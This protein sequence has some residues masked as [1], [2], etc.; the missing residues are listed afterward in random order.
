MIVCRKGRNKKRQSWRAGR[1][2]KEW[3]E[4]RPSLRVL[5]T[6]LLNFHLSIRELGNSSRGL[7]RGAESN[8]GTK[9][10]FTLRFFNY[11]WESWLMS[12]SLWC[13]CLAGIL[14]VSI[15]EVLMRQLMEYSVQ[16]L[17]SFFFFF[18]FFYSVKD[19]SMCL[20]IYN[21]RR[22]GREKTPEIGLFCIDDTLKSWECRIGQNHCM[23]H[24]YFFNREE[25]NHSY[26]RL[27]KEI[28]LLAIYNLH[29]KEVLSSHRVRGKRREIII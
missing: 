25:I 14:V 9:Y 3:R 29:N 18:F 16:S 24:G 21:G 13:I 8:K 11:P 20:F 23:I 10:D 28:N 26:L 17:D 15:A 5:Y 22:Y 1:K 6:L 12:L 2:E 4:R 19:N 27:Q 7:E